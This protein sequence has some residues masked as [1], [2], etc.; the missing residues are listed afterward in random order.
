MNTQESVYERWCDLYFLFNEF[1]GRL[2]LSDVRQTFFIDT[3]PQRLSSDG[4]YHCF[5]LLFLWYRCLFRFVLFILILWQQYDINNGRKSRI[6]RLIWVNINGCCILL[7]IIALLI[8]IFAFDKNH[9]TISILFQKGVIKTIWVIWTN[10]LPWT[11]D[12]YKSMIRL[13]RYFRS[14]SFPHCTPIQFHRLS[15]LQSN[16][17]IS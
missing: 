2:V 13:K 5:H 4:Y 10:Q 17:F 12:K 6:K 14:Y 8:F 3:K 11:N 16:R 7:L 9:N 1:K 15:R